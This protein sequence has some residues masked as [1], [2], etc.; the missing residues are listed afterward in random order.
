M[1]K[2]AHGE[3]SVRRQGSG[4]VASIMLTV[5]G[6]RHRI[7]RAGKTAADAV[8]RRNEAV[9]A[10]RRG[11]LVKDSPVTFGQ[12]FEAWRDGPLRAGRKQSTVDQYAG[13]VRVHALPAWTSTRVAT[14][15]P[16]AVERLLLDLESSL[17]ASSRRSLYA[18][19]RS[20]FAAA[21]R[22]GLIG[23]NPV[24][25]VQRPRSAKSEPRAL[26]AT[27][28]RALIE[29]AGSD[30]LAVTIGVVAGTGLRRGELL[31]LRWEDLDLDTG[32]M[33]VR[34]S[35][36]RASDGLRERAPKSDSGIRTVPL[37]PAVVQLLRS[38]RKAQAIER[39]AVP[40]WEDPGY[41][42]TSETGSALEPRN[43][44]AWY[45]TVATRA[46]V[47]DRGAHALRH[48]AATAMLS[49]GATVRDVA[50]VLG[51]SSPVVTLE[52]Y[53]RAVPEAQRT[54]VEAASAVLTS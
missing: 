24:E 28:V 2:R 45:A 20:L 37:A 30:R 34:R 4:Y 41:V 21:Q 5:D 17:S 47:S 15:R 29:A 23:T 32:E 6:E 3:G 49:S 46:G 38:H 48:Y 10:L 42:F 12:Y 8:R 13:L 14:I 27:E 40:H 35:L 25:R 22:D 53:A 44:S 19:L 43:W 39:L 7:N 51:H 54:A 1:T 31:G 11:E 9:D 50:D 33:H 52:I 16:S 36:S 18:A 26:T